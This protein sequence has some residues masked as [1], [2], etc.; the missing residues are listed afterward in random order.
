MS[1]AAAVHNYR[2]WSLNWFLKQTIKLSWV[3]PPSR[4]GM[5]KWSDTHYPFWWQGWSKEYLSKRKREPHLLSTY[6]LVIHLGAT[7]Q[8][9]YR[10]LFSIGCVLY[11]KI[12]LT[13]ISLDLLRWRILSDDIKYSNIIVFLTYLD[14]LCKREKTELKRNLIEWSAQKYK[15]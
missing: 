5:S 13:L 8:T 6:R 12:K 14:E 2:R 7:D 1:I 3:F 11:D 4:N 9:D 10:F 15:V